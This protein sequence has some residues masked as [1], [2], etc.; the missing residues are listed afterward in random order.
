MALYK[1]RADLRM[2]LEVIL[3]LTT[4]IIF[5]VFALKPTVLTIIS[6]VKEVNKKEDVVRALDLKI[7]NLQRARS[8]YQTQQQN[9]SIIENAIPNM[10]SPNIIVRQIEGLAA[11]NSVQ[12][13]GVSIGEVT[14][15]GKTPDKKIDADLKPLPAGSS[16]VPV[17]I[18]VTGAY[19][20]L[21]TMVK[22]IENLRIP[23]QFDVLGINSSTSDEKLTIVAVVSGRVPFLK[24]EN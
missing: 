18:S 4:I 8:T 11:K 19:Q 21:N 3:S 22:D 7:G 2:F 24:N 12:I 6:L 14:L 10:P 23:I 17:A 15:I 20:N 5:S 9:I 13:L 1:K 16:Q